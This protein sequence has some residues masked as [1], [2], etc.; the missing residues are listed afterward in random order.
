MRA[1]PGPARIPRPQTKPI[2]DG[3][4]VAPGL[5]DMD[6]LAA[7]LKVSRSSVERIVDQTD[8]PRINFGSPDAIRRHVLRFHPGDVL[9]WCRRR[10]G[11]GNG[12]PPGTGDGR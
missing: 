3:A 11:N 6:D 2:G 5:L 9:E 4:P 12:T 10:G 8:I 7:F 1:D